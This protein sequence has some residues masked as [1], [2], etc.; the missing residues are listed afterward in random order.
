M[1]MN[2]VPSTVEVPYTTVYHLEFIV[3]LYEDL[4][5]ETEHETKPES[6]I[7]NEIMHKHT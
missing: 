7:L 4:R 1:Y 5:L 6:E 2:I 3:E